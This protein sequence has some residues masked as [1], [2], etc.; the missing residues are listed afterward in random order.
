[1]F[2]YGQ[3]LGLLI[4]LP[5][6]CNAMQMVVGGTQEIREPMLAIHLNRM[7]PEISFELDED[8]ETTLQ[9][10]FNVSPEEI[11]LYCMQQDNTI[12]VRSI[13]TQQGKKITRKIFLKRLINRKP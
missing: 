2:K 13:D 11:F 6:S 1:M 12:T 7:R 10:E 5:I 9:Q 3:L 8:I 4:C